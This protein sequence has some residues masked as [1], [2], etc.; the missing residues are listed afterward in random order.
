MNYLRNLFLICLTFIGSDAYRILAV[1]H[2]NSRSHNIFL[3]GIAKGLAKR[4]NQVDVVSHFELENPP[5]NYRTIINL[6][7]TRP[8]LMNNFTIEYASQLS[9]DIV[10]FIAGVYGNELCEL[11]ALD[12]MQKLIKNPAMDPPYD[13]V[14]TEVFSLKYSIIY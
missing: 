9:E 14:F 13:L 5:K 11:M 3:E 10:R 12:E 1:F 4:G 2:F 8:N 6:G 7:G